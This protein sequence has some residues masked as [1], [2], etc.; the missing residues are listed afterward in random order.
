MRKMTGNFLDFFYGELHCAAW[1]RPGIAKSS[2][3][4]R[5]AQTQGLLFRD[6]RIA[7]VVI[8]KREVSIYSSLRHRTT[9]SAVCVV[10][11]TAMVR[12]DRK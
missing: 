12:V 1:M 10:M 2:H 5:S 9:R 6:G 3:S 8:G 11:D 4:S 7:F